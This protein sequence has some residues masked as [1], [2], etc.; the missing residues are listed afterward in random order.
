MLC[1]TVHNLH[2]FQYVPILLTLIHNT[3]HM[4]IGSIEIMKPSNHVNN[5]LS[6]SYFFPLSLILSISSLCVWF[7]GRITVARI[8]SFKW[9]IEW[10][11]ISWSHI[12][13]VC[14]IRSTSSFIEYLILIKWNTLQQSYSEYFVKNTIDISQIFSSPTFFKLDGINRFN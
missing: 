14:T 4:V 11:T 10:I 5:N 13:W 2:H 8:S 12:F 6:L 9:N 3:I 7:Y 1:A